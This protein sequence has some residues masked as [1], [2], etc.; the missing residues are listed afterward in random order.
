MVIFIL[1]MPE[2][3]RFF[4]IIIGMFAKDHSPP[5]FHAKYGEF[6]G[7]FSIGSGEMIEGNLPRRAIALIQD[8]AELHHE[9]L[10]A[11]WVEAL[12]DSPDFKK[13]APLK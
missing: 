6:A 5:H 1:Q 7:I 11:N 4:G 2:I 10:L 3:S 8:W 13:I 12:K 9:E